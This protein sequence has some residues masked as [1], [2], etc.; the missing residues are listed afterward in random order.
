MSVIL[1]RQTAKKRI[2]PEVIG[3]GGI[4]NVLIY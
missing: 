3:D 2:K 4:F 1:P